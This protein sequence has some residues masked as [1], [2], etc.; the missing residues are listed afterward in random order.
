MGACW[1]GR[2]P[3]S[4]SATSLGVTLERVNEEIERLRKNPEQIPDPV[5]ARQVQPRSAETEALPAAVQK[6][7]AREGTGTVV[8]Q[9]GRRSLHKSNREATLAGPIVTLDGSTL[10]PWS[11]PSRDPM[12]CSAS[13]A[14]ARYKT[15]RHL[16][17][18]RHPF[19]N[20]NSRWLSAPGSRRQ[21]CHWR[22]RR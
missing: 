11:G 12:N 4:P 10:P 14:I 2:G 1:N 3:R 21:M 22:S 18:G 17:D 15:G 20:N 13:D 7:A 19:G 16:R 6:E 9:A 8:P 5:H